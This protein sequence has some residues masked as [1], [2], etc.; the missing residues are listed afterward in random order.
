VEPFD[1]VLD[2]EPK[3]H[4]QEPLKREEKE[5]DT[6]FLETNTNTHKRGSYQ[7]KL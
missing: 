3:G 5:D 7:L 4:K 6:I 2:V 1:G